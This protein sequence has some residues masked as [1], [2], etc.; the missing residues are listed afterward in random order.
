MQDLFSI[1]PELPDGFSYFPDFLSEAEEEEVLRL[2]R[3]QSLRPMIFQGF[4]ARRKTAGFGYDYHFDS[5]RLHKGK[6]IPQAFLPLIA[7]A[8]KT[9]GIPPSHFAQLLLT[10]Y[11]PGTVINWHRDAPP[12][13][14]I[15]G[16]SLVSDCR[17]RL[18]PHDKSRQ[19]RSALK[20][21]TVERRSLYLMTGAARQDWEHSIAPLK[22]LRYSVTLRT[23]RGLPADYGI[24]P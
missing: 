10:E 6:P 18:R 7:K 19:T 23:L 5:R 24:K 16:I 15:A 4:E 1:P 17:F 20:S 22:G 13:G 11:A 9:L 8:G 12:F 14:Q 2:I 3:E 21:F